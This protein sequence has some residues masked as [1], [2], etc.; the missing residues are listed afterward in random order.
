[1]TCNE[2]FY[3]GIGH[4]TDAYKQVCVYNEEFREDL[5]KVREENA[6]LRLMVW[7]MRE[8]LADECKHCSEHGFPCDID[9]DMQELGIRI[10]DL[11]SDDEL[12]IE[13]E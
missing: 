8:C 9:H 12:G 11:A 1:M 7:I 5:E 10:C 2:M 3:A 13:A 4:I 6:K